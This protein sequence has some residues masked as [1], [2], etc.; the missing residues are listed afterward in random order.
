MVDLRRLLG[1]LRRSDGPP[2]L[3]PQP[4]LLQLD[5]LLGTVRAA[6]VEIDVA[7]RGEQTEL[8]PGVD[9]TAY[10]IVQEALTNA[11]KH[12]NAGRIRID[13]GYERNGI[14]LEIVDNGSGAPTP[15]NQRPDPGGHGLI[16]MRERVSVF[17]GT[18][19]TGPVAAGGWSVHARLPV[20]PTVAE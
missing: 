15:G 19:S 3:T 6:G 9:L 20:R 16:G 4:G 14:D 1:L 18:L 8:P 5:D 17:G 10:R 2:A 11:L 7:V 12:A 13:V